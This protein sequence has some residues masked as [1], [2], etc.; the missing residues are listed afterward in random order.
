MNSYRESL[1]LI[2]TTSMS[3]HTIAQSLSCAHN[4]IKKYH[5]NA[6]EQSLNWQKVNE[7]NDEQQNCIE[8]LKQATHAIEEKSFLT[9]G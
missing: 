7:L 6:S 5:N 3:N 2:L 1:R 4:T 8:K 9:Y